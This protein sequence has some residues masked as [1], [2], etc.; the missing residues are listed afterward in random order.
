MSAVSCKARRVARI[1]AGACLLGAT[2]SP[3]QDG[4]TAVGNRPSTTSAERVGGLAAQTATAS[5]QSA[6]VP[7]QKPGRRGQ[8]VIAPLPLSSPALGTGI[9][10]VIGYIF[11]VSTADKTSPPSMVVAAGLLTNNDSRAF[12][13][14]GQ[15]YLKENTYRLTAAFGHGNLNYNLYGMGTIAGNT[16]IKL[17]LQ[18][19]GQIFFAEA[20]RNFG[21]NFFVGPRF[22]SGHSVITRRNSTESEVEPPADLGL[23]TTLT[24]LGA[25][26]LR[27]TRPNRFYP[28]TGMLLDFTSDFFAQAL[29]SKYSFQSY[30]VTFNKYGSISPRQVLA[31]NAFFCAT[32]G[33]PPFYGNCIY[34]TNNELRGYEAGRFIDRYMIATQLE[35]RLVLPKRL[36]LVGF[37]GIGGVAPGGRVFLRSNNCLPSAGAGARFL[38]SKQYHVNLRADFSQG[39]E[40][41]TFSMGVAEAF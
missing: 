8:F 24:S 19:K 29:G 17:P 22:L 16:A 36:G 40:G 1:I 11:R 35:Y 32:G 7:E 33:Q 39:K 18:Q 26:L 34:G 14:G 25:R 3:A 2:L 9:V 30:R 31:F 5:E 27:D 23:Q 28:T 13:L 4:P 6:Q 21:G 15:F 37:G 41:H 38:L 20:L 10:P 12:A